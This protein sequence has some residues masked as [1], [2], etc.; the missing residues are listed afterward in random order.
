MYDLLDNY[1]NTNYY[2]NLWRHSYGGHF[3][4]GVAKSHMTL[5]W[6]FIVRYKNGR[7]LITWQKRHGVKRI[8]VHV[9]KCLLLYS[10][11]RS[12]VFCPT[13]TR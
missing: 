6:R 7:Q 1:S 5:M 8:H 9:Y 13:T 11:C 2:F 10:T 12:V 3:D 4:G